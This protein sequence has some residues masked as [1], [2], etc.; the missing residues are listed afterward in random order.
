MKRALCRLAFTASSPAGSRALARA[1]MFGRWNNSVG[2]EG[3]R[4]SLAMFLR[5][6]MPLVGI[7]QAESTASGFGWPGSGHSFFDVA[8]TEDDLVLRLASSLELDRAVAPSA[9]RERRAPLR[10]EGGMTL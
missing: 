8:R 10:A 5:P 7:V 2:T 9:R 3:V 1:P 6:R 4:P